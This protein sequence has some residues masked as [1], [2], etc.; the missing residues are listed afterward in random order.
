MPNTLTVALANLEAAVK[1]R[2]RGV[3]KVFDKKLNQHVTTRALCEVIAS[4]VLTVA[5]QVESKGNDAIVAALIK[6][7]EAGDSERLVAIQVDDACH[8]LEKYAEGQ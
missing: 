5:G 8:L 1:D 7:S 6:G 2:V 4:D 3:R